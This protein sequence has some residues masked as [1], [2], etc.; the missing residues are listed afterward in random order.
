MSKILILLKTFSERLW[1]YMFTK[2]I[3]ISTVK[4]IKQNLKDHFPKFLKKTLNL[5][6]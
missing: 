6:N 5:K 3:F 1:C 4:S 2:F